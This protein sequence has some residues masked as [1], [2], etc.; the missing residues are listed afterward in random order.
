[1]KWSFL[2]LI[3]LWSMSAW[4]LSCDCEIQAHSPL[5]GPYKMG[6]KILEKYSLENFSGL[7][8]KNI[9]NCQKLCLDEFHGEMPL[10]RLKALLITY[11]MELIE[12][13]KL[14]FNCTGLTTLKYP[15]RVRAKLGSFNLGL[16]A[17]MIQVVNHEEVCF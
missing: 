17:D 14:G 3:S 13:K 7:S 16:V 10:N 9:Q 6:P 1:M 12:E 5:T 8:Q 4:S 15:V 11:S 2:F